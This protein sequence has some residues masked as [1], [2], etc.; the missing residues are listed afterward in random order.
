MDSNILNYWDLEAGGALF[1]SE[2]IRRIFPRPRSEIE[3]YNP[4]MNSMPSWLPNRFKRGDPYR[5]VTMGFARLPGPGYEA[6]H[7]ELKGIDPEDY[8]DIYKLKILADVAPTSQQVGQLR[9]SL[10]QRRAA[11]VTTEFENTELDVIMGDLS[12]R[13]GAIRDFEGHE[14]QIRIPIISDITRAIYS[15]AL[16]AVR[17]VTAP[18]EYLIPAGFRPVQKL[19]SENRTAIETYEY[20]RLYATPNAFWNKPIRDWIRPS[21]YT[22]LHA[23][24]WNGKPSFVEER[25]DIDSHFDKLNFMKFMTLSQTAE[26]PQDRKRFLRLASQTRY[27]VNPQGDAMSIY[28]SLPKEEQAYFV[29]FANANEGDRDRIL[30]M[31]PEDQEQL[32]QAVWSRMDSGET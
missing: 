1:M 16:S 24:G 21:F 28:M 25:N 5:S 27:G 22:A 14:N 12:K 29:A 6:L 30:E 9:E 8:P 10:F 20:D 19:L 4:I 17:H 18:A 23:M 26:N 11:G 15:T 13:I 32:Y 31:V 3:Q 2:P 7:P